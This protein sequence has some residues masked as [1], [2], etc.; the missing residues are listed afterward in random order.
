M[1]P[2]LYVKEPGQLSWYSYGLDVSIP[3]R[4]RLFL[5]FTASKPTLGLTQ[6]PI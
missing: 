5:Y 2:Q 3:D 4:A 1:L 6:L